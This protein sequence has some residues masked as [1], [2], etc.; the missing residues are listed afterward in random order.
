MQSFPSYLIKS[1]NKKNLKS[2]N[3]VYKDY[4]K[5][6]IYLDRHG[7]QLVSGENILAQNGVK[8]EK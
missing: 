4:V 3:M 8:I 6:D 7:I 2:N 5:V 1:Y